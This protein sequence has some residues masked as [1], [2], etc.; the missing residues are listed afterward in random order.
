MEKDYTPFPPPASI[1]SHPPAVLPEDQ[2]E[3]QQKVAKHFSVPEYVLPR[4]ENGGLT[5]EEK[6]W[7]VRFFFL[8]ILAFLTVQTP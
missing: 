6:F 5:E 4:V 2:A 7:L 1:P 8:V 3:L